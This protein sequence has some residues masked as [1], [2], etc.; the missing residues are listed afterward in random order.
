M[1]R[2]FLTAL[3]IIVVLSINAVEND[4][5]IINGGFEQDTDGNGMADNW[6][7]VGDA[8]VTATWDLDEGFM[9]QFSQKITCSQSRNAR[10]EEHGAVGGGNV[11]QVF[12]CCKAGRNPQPSGTGSHLRHENLV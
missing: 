6:Y 2:L 11:V 9:E 1:R 3:M 12:F 8:G 10:S 7:F 5:M 4:S